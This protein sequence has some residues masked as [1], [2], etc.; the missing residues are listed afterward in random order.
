[1][2][3]NRKSTGLHRTID[4]IIDDLSQKYQGD[5]LEQDI[6]A[7]FED[8]IRFFSGREE[9]FISFDELSLEQ[10]EELYNEITTIINLLKKLGQSIDRQETIKILSQSLIGSFSKKSRGLIIS[11]DPFS[12]TEELRLKKEFSII[13]IQNLYKERQ[14]KALQQSTKLK[15]KDLEQISKKIN[16]IKKLGTTFSL[17]FKKSDRSISKTR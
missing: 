15:E 12:K 1:M 14:H 2:S 10:K 9:D 6:I 3:K 11:H 16:E 17:S 5:D 7:L 13:T 8:I 4:F